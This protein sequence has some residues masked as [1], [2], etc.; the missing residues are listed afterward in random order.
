[1]DIIVFH[2]EESQ[3]FDF[4]DGRIVFLR[5]KDRMHAIHPVSTSTFFC[6]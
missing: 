6:Q 5:E 4:D 3:R 2:L 1:M